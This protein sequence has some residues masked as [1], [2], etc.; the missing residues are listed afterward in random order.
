MFEP[1]KLEGEE[2]KKFIE[3]D[4]RELTKEEKESLRKAYEFYLKYNITHA[5][6]DS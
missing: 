1:I 2:A 6:Y 3:Y 5:P 4:E